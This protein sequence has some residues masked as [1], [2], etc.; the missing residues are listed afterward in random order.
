LGRGD[1]EKGLPNGLR[2]WAIADAVIAE[3]GIQLQVWR[4]SERKSGQG[5]KGGGRRKVPPRSSWGRSERKGDWQNLK[6]KSATPGERNQKTFYKVK[7][8]WELL[9]RGRRPRPQYRRRCRGKR[10]RKPLAG[11]VWESRGGKYKI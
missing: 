10:G 4:P 6:D 11:A 7:S 8:K 1:R 5:E 3:V 9:M 2:K